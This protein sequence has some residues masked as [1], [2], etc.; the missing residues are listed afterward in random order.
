MNIFLEFILEI[1]KEIISP[2]AL[3]YIVII[4]IL[5]WIK[6]NDLHHIGIWQ[7]KHEKRS[8]KIWQKVDKNSIDI[9]GLKKGKIDK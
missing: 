9:E 5:V 6:F 4:V 7:I 1:F 2:Q 3:L 8:E